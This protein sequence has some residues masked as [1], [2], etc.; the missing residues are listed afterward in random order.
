LTTPNEDEARMKELMCK[1]AQRV[2]LVADGSK[3]HRR[4]FVQFADLQAVDLFITDA[5]MDDATREAFE[6]AG[7]DI[8]QGV[9][10]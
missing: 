5:T 1:K 4:S 9:G 7:V 6:A 8:V 10:T 2:I 3:L